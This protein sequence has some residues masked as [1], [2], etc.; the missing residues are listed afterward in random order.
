MFSQEV[1]AVPCCKIEALTGAKKALKNVFPSW[2]IPSPVSSDQGTRFT[3]QIPRAF[4]KTLQMSWNDHYPISLSHQSRSR[5]LTEKEDSGRASVN[6][7]GCWELR[8]LWCLSFPHLRRP[9]PPAQGRCPFLGQGM[10]LHH[11]SEP[12]HGNGNAGSLTCCTTRELQGK[13]C[14]DLQPSDKMY[15]CEQGWNVNFALPDASRIQEVSVSI[16]FSYFRQTI[17]CL[18]Q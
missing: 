15:L 4:T 12:R 11:S 16:L 6:Y 17:I 8:M 10:N 2:G 14:P 5:E 18:V 1:T 7:W 3:G 9:P 13:L